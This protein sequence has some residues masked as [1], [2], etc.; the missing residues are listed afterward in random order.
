MR[1]D[2]WVYGCVVVQG[3]AAGQPNVVAWMEAEFSAKEEAWQAQ[4]GPDFNSIS[5]TR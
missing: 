5:P 4:V 1:I 2:G 3:E